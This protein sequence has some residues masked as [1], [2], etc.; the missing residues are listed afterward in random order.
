M[1]FLTFSLFF[2][3]TNCKNKTIFEGPFPWSNTDSENKVNQ[4]DDSY[5]N[6]IK[7][8]VNTKM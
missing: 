4:S 6:R 5:W 1:K 3:L 8:E 7:Q 2:G